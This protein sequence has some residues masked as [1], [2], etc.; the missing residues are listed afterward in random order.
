MNIS[1]WNTNRAGIFCLLAVLLLMGGGLQAQPVKKK[2]P[3]VKSTKTTH[4]KAITK[5]TAKT[6][7]AAGKTHAS[8]GKGHVLIHKTHVAV[9]TVKPTSVIVEEGDT[10]EGTAVEAPVAPVNNSIAQDTALYRFFDA[11]S[12]ADSNIVSILHLGDSHIQAGFFPFTTANLLVQDFGCAGRGWVFPYTVAGTN[13]PGDYRWNSNGRWQTDRVI[14]RYKPDPLG[15]GAIVMTTQ[16]DQPALAYNGREDELN[17]STV[18]EADLYFDAGTDDVSVTAPGAGV[19]VSGVPFSEAGE[20]LRKATL[21]FDNPVQS[22][23][24]RW[25]AKSSRPFRFYGA[26]LLN[27]HNGI[28]YN[29]VGIN[30]AMYQHYN[31]S[32]SVLTAE[33]EV[34]QPQLVIISLGTNEAFGSLSVSQFHDQLDSM[35]T[36]IRRELPS[37]SILLTTPSEAKRVSKR[38]IRKKVGKKY[39]TYYKISYYPNPYVAIV[40]QQIQRYCRE[41]GIACWNFNALNKSMAGAFSGAWQADHIHFN[42]RGYQLQGKL[43]YEALHQSYTKYLKEVKSTKHD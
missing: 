42:V 9:K 5:T 38:A 31:E 23:Q 19:D 43:L 1:S 14:D 15:P 12:Q 20:T 21:T 10:D 4:A 13:G 39:R 36:L 32:N 41:N 8:A 3:V 29:A 37:A 7:L 35:V 24:V 28:L 25:D 30:G 34:M 2:P 17:N 26:M 22:F 6:H 16:S 11:L 27:G 40:T 33:M 18:Q